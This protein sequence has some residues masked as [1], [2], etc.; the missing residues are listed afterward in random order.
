MSEED[1]EK[2]CVL[3]LMNGRTFYCRVND[4]LK[5]VVAGK[6]RDGYI[7]ITEP[8]ISM[9]FQGG[10]VAVASLK[11][12]SGQFIGPV[13]IA[14]A[15]IVS[16]MEMRADSDWAKGLDRVESGEVKIATVMRPSSLQMPR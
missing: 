8:Y 16:V 3:D 4:D 6:R 12:M 5:A 10:T 11:E 15:S 2:W 14:V 7:T 1:A 13:A 9:P